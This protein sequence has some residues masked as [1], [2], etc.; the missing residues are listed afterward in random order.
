[1]PSWEG[2]EC[3]LFIPVTKMNRVATRGIPA[4]FLTVREVC[5]MTTFSSE[6]GETL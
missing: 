5:R 1:M 4:H 3:L 6:I 2:K